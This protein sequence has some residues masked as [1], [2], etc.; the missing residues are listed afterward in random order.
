MARHHLYEGCPNDVGNIKMLLQQLVR[1]ELH[2]RPTPAES[3][4][5]FD[6]STLTGELAAQLN[7]ASAEYQE[8]GA[9]KSRK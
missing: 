1:G 5:R 2:L 7:A 6:Y 3:V 8:S 9:S 4:E